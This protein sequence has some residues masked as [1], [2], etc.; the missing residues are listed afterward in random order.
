MILYD[1]DMIVSISGVRQNIIVQNGQV[2]LSDKPYPGEIYRTKDVG[3]GEIK[4]GN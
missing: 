2:Y 3:P 4:E 1:G